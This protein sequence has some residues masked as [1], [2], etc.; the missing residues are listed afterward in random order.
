MNELKAIYVRLAALEA[1]IGT[2]AVP[3]TI[4]RDSP[5]AYWDADGIL[6]ELRPNEFYFGVSN[7]PHDA[8]EV[9]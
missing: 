5:A 7:P 2:V 9:E 1:K 3:L 6:R 4:T 8:E